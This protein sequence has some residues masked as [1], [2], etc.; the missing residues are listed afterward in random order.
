VAVGL[1]IVLALHRVRG[2][3]NVAEADSLRF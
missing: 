3:T 1:A 2:T